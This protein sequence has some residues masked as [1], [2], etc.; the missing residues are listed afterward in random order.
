[1]LSIMPQALR[2]W[3]YEVV[4]YIGCGYLMGDMRVRG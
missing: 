2:L 3:K 4:S 1:M